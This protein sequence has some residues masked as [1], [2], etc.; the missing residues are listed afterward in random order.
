M[1][2]TAKRAARGLE[3]TLMNMPDD[4]ADRN[5]IRRLMEEARRRGGEALENVEG[6]AYIRIPGR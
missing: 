3:I 4:Q 5:A 6:C 1:S 2:V